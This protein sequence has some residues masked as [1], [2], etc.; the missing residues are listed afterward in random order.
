MEL[1][2]IIVPVY[3]AEVYLEKCI[4]SLIGQTYNNIEIIL[5]NDGSNDNSLEI[6]NRYKNKDKR[7]IV[8]N[9]NNSGVSDTRNYGI[10]ICKGKYLCFVDSDDYVKENYVSSLIF[11]MN[12]HKLSVCNY[13][14][15]NGCIEEKNNRIF[16]NGTK[17]SVEIMEKILDGKS[18]DGYVWNKMFSKSIIN[19]NNIKFDSELSIWEDMIFV[20][21]YLNYIDEVT[22]SQNEEYIYRINNESLSKG[23]KNK[24]RILVEEYK[25]LKM[26]KEKNKNLTLNYYANNL[27]YSILLKLY[28][29]KKITKKEYFNKC[30][31]DININELNKKNKIKYL[32]INILGLENLY[33]RKI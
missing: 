16:K 31:S 2:S 26:I 14:L 27:T 24:N 33:R 21:D 32:L 11:S 23:E 13:K 30:N 19:K 12:D 1:V 5:I 7:V 15:F 9:K 22:F 20:I 3:N 17:R 25:A 6:C 4:E 8:I 10:S 18:F 29:N 28:I